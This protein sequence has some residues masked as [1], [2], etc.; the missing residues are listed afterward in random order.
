MGSLVSKSK[1]NAE[2]VRQSQPSGLYPNFYWNQKTVR[3]L[4]AAKRLAPITPG[5]EEANSEQD[6]ECP[7]CFLNYQPGLNRSVC[8]RQSVCSECYLQI[9]RPNQ[10]VEC[11]FCMNERWRVAF[12]GP[13]SAEQLEREHDEQEKVRLLEEKVRR[14]E[15]ERD[16]K[17]EE[18]RL[19]KREQAD[20][21]RPVVQPEQ[22]VAATPPPPPRAHAEPKRR[23]SPQSET[24]S[25]ATIVSSSSSSSAAA[26]GDSSAA[27][28]GGSTT[29]TTASAAAAAASDGSTAMLPLSA[30]HSSSSSSS[31]PSPA[32]AAAAA[33][34]ENDDADNVVR[35][36]VDHAD[37]VH[38]D[39]THKFAQPHRHSQR[40]HQHQ[41]QH[42]E[43]SPQAAASVDPA[44]V[45]VPHTTAVSGAQPTEVGS[46]VSPS[47]AQNE[48]MIDDMLIAEAI[49]LSLAQQ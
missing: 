36:H 38:A 18:A 35:N 6:E 14:E 44:A 34:S 11:P 7:I 32:A 39:S 4:I 45:T 49:R 42:H 9:R 46:P 20:A 27:T 30:A 22:E 29:A 37:S 47:A 31:A 13:K 21:L 16:R 3:N 15:I 10:P 2:L 48:Q 28:T 40:E 17:R 1:E 23:V 24:A 25:I 41:H 5:T 8:C 33:N 19:L 12:T 26:A 43:A